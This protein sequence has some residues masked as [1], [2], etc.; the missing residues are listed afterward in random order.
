MGV[1]NGNTRMETYVLKSE[2]TC[3]S[4]TDN[5]TEKV[6]LQNKEH[7]STPYSFC[8]LYYCNSK[9]VST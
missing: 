9:P 4:L 2:V 7:D 6:L 5:K 3:I 1:L 8:V